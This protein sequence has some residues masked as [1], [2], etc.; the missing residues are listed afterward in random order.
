[1]HQDASKCIMIIK[2][3]PTCD[4]SIL[5][6]KRW[7]IMSNYIFDLTTIGGRLGYAAKQIGGATELAR[8]TGISQSTVSRIVQGRETTVGVMLSLFKGLQSQGVTLDW[9]LLGEGDPESFEPIPDKSTPGIFLK[10]YGEEELNS[11]APIYFD[12]AWF[13]SS[14][15]RFPHRCYAFRSVD[16]E[17]KGI[18]K[19]SWTIFDTSVIYGDGIYLSEIRGAAVIRQLQFLPTGEIK[20]RS[21][22]DAFEDFILSPDQQDL[23]K[24]IGRLVWWEAH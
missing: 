24:I 1:M 11:E 16:D 14:V 9:L 22:S 17:L 21:H 18:R 23:I 19:G 10:V 13:T 7:R 3:M 2:Y 8:R 6:C 15:S 5:S 20:I 12:E 4:V